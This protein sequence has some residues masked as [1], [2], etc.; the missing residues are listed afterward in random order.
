[1][2]L[3]LASDASNAAVYIQNGKFYNA[4]NK[5][6]IATKSI[7]AAAVKHGWSDATEVYGNLKGTGLFMMDS[8]YNVRSRIRDLDEQSGQTSGLVQATRDQWNDSA[9]SRQLLR[10]NKTSIALTGTKYAYEYFTPGHFQDAFFDMNNLQHTA[11][12]ALRY[13]D[14]DA[15]ASTSDDVSRNIL[16]IDSVIDYQLPLKTMDSSANYIEPTD[17]S[18]YEQHARIAWVYNKLVRP[19]FN[20]TKSALAEITSWSPVPP[21]L[22]V[23]V[24]DVTG[25]VKEDTAVELARNKNDFIYD[26]AQAH[27]D[28]RSRAP[29]MIHVMAN[30][31]AKA[32]A[33]N[34]GSQFN[35]NKEADLIALIDLHPEETLKAFSMM[36][37][38]KDTNSAT[39]FTLKNNATTSYDLLTQQNA[40]RMLVKILQ[41][42]VHFGKSP[43][44]FKAIGATAKDAIDAY[45][46]EVKQWASDMGN[47]MG[48]FGDDADVFSMV[49]HL[50]YWIAYLSQYS[51]EEIAQEIIDDDDIKNI[52]DQARALMLG[53]L[54]AATKGTLTSSRASDA[55]DRIAGL[56]ALHLAGIPKMLV[57]IAFTLRG[58]N[59]FAN[60]TGSKYDA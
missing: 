56:N 10:K 12:V 5:N 29:C 36:K 27:Y 3:A 16:N 52:S 42:L 14:L 11:N 25:F 46:E 49:Q 39:A 22:F 21:Q 18:S 24:S 53:L 32:A 59:V 48:V 35:K 2:T 6:E 4:N 33:A 58:I 60:L 44:Y 9:T 57:D 47:S 38:N 19:S 51:P 23:D 26:T 1:M 30:Y 15:S 55:A 50:G 41:A 37:L 43:S 17:Y 34:D 45:E 13:F 8:V 40:S 31:L 54:L 7:W 28:N 20:N